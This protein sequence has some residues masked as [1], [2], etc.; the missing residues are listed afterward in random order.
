MAAENGEMIALLR[1]LIGSLE[2]QNEQ[3][4]ELI[5]QK[6]LVQAYGVDDIRGIIETNIS[7]RDPTF[8]P[9]FF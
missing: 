3:K 8:Q 1:T 7:R 4:D 9:D 6:P 5:R 2:Q